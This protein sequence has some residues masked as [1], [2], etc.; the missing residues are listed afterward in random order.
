[1]D[2]YTTHFCGVYHCVDMYVIATWGQQCCQHLWNWQTA[3]TAFPIQVAS[4]SLQEAV[5]VEPT[6]FESACTCMLPMS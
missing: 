3:V 2:V 6:S 5:L 1:M 4:C